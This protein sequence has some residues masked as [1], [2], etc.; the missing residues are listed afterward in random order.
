MSDMPTAE[1]ALAEARRSLNALYLEVPAVIADDVRAKMEAAFA[2]LAVRS[3]SS[4]DAPLRCEKCGSLDVYTASARP[5]AA[6]CGGR[7]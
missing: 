4:R 6:R 1:N 5:S 7:C 2:A 3:D